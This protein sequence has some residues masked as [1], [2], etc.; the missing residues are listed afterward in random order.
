MG[1]KLPA[2]IHKEPQRHMTPEG[3]GQW[4]KYPRKPH[5]ER[6]HDGQN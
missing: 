1:D 4:N 5:P 2:Q 3:K 6:G